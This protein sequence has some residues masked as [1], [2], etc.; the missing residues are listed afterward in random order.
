MIGLCWKSQH[1]AGSYL[2]ENVF[3]MKGV[4]KMVAIAL[5]VLLLDGIGIGFLARIRHSAQRMSCANNIKQFALFCQNYHDVGQCFPLGTV[6][7]PA[8][9][10]DKRLSWVVLLDP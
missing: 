8:L 5:A 7:N 2:V 9:P 4:V 6:P 1:S 3:L 10:P